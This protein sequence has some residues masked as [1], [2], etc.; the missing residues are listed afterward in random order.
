MNKIMRH[1]ILMNK[2]PTLPRMGLV[3]LREQGMIRQI[4]LMI[5]LYLMIKK[6]KKMMLLRTV[7]LIHLNPW[8]LN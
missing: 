2:I 1:L 5:R 6:K 3:N 8:R 7:L 4:T